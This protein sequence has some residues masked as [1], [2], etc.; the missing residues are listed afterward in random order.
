M[1]RKSLIASLA[2]AAMAITLTAADEKKAEGKKAFDNLH[3]EEALA[4]PLG[5]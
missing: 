1:L 4:F 5:G 3:S 2:I